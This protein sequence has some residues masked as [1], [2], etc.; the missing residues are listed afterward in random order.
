MVHCSVKPSV[1]FYLWKDNLGEEK[2]KRERE[3]E[4][5]KKREKNKNKPCT[6]EAE[7]PRINSEL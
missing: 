2:T 6:H 7:W 3:R 1:T 5:K 4:K